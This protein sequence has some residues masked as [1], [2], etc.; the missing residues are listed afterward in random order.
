MDSLYPVETRAAL[1][2][3]PPPF[4]LAEFARNATR[5]A[6]LATFEGKVFQARADV[7]WDTLDAFLLEVVRLLDGI[8][9]VALL[10]SMTGASSEEVSAAIALLLAKGLIVESDDAT[11]IDSLPLAA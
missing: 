11:E 7:P 6:D 2:T 8:A 4:D 5:S 3:A 1:V 9:P 10:E